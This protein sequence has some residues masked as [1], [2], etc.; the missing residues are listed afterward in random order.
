[1]DFSNA[2]T[3]ILVPFSKTVML[4][5]YKLPP[6]AQLPVNF[7]SCHCNSIEARNVRDYVLFFQSSHLLTALFTFFRSPPGIVIWTYELTITACDFIHLKKEPRNTFCF[8]MKE[9]RTYRFSGQRQI[10][11]REIELQYL[12]I[13]T[14]YIWLKVAL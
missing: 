10:W 3:F 9:T 7:L 6:C 1:M 14:E 2:L 11:V 8:V 12:R 4:Y 5:F 13:G